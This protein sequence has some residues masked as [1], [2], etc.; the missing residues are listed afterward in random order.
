[1]AGED[2]GMMSK[3]NLDRVRDN[4][5]QAETEDLLDRI[6]VYRAGMEDEALEIIDAELRRREISEDVVRRHG[7]RHADVI[8]DEAGL[9]QKCSFCRR[10]ALASGWG[11]QRLFGAI[12][13]FPR[14][15]YY[16]DQ[17]CPLG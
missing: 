3:L 9:A 4:V 12:P 1:M 7:Q 11:W 5:R 10:P 17:H 15:L 8:R 14:F 16:C 13:V 2:L 6:T